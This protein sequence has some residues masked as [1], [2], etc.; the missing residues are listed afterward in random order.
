MLNMVVKFLMMVN[1]SVE[2]VLVVDGLMG[3]VVGV[4]MAMRMTM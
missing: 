1:G 3:S 4:S 2:I